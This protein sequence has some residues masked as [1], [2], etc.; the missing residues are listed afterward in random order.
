MSDFAVGLAC[1]AVAVLAFGCVRRGYITIL[2]CL[3]TATSYWARVESK[4]YY[5]YHRPPIL[6]LQ[7]KFH[8]HGS[9]SVAIAVMMLKHRQEYWM[10][11]HS[12]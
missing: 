11:V 4:T 8:C 2:T 9:C 1:A 12:T 3:R 5:D 6:L 10:K 7:V